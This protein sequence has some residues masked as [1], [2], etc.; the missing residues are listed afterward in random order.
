VT[1]STRT[2]ALDRIVAVANALPPKV[3]DE[4]V[5][6]GGTVL[7]LL[8]DVDT[9][10]D[11]PRPTIDVDAVT[12]TV[13]Y[14][15]YGQME[16]ALRAARFKHAQ[17]G[18]ISRWIA[19]NGEIFDLSTA[20]DHP[21]G[22]GAIVDRMAIQTAIPI[23]GHPHLRQVSGIGYFLMKAAAFS[24][25]GAQ[26]PYESKDLADLGVLLVGRETP[27]CRRGGARR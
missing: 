13:S 17:P 10:F 3:R 22:T 21:G 27:P 11:T 16:E 9:R 25:R 14:T 24:D 26:A 5:F 1:T 20:G 2:A 19:P 8:V 4:V 18:P 7:P 12:A 6:I 15:Q 23:S